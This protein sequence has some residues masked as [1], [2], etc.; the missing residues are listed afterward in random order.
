MIE[1]INRAV[2]VGAKVFT[3]SYGGFS[4]YRTA[5]NPWKAIDAAVAD[6]MTVFISAGNEATAALHDSV[7]VAPTPRRPLFPWL[8]T[9]RVPVRPTVHPI[10][11]S[12]LDRPE[13][14]AITM[15]LCPAQILQQR[16]PGGES[17]TA[18]FQAVT[19]IEVLKA[20][21]TIDPQCFGDLFKNLLFSAVQFRH[22]RKCAFDSLLSDFGQ[23]DFWKRRCFLY[24]WP[25][26][27]SRRCHCCRRMGS[28]KTMD[29][30]SRIYVLLYVRRNGRN[31]RDVQQSRPSHRRRP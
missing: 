9:I 23:G 8:L 29:K 3:M 16:G 2:T 6:G 7:S 13:P 25:S 15:F 12:H 17:L 18:C 19:A 11:S 10:Y 31:A 20:D 30:L 24:R 27:S 1:A 4:T 21:S 22:I 14:S 28:A 26:R 5:A